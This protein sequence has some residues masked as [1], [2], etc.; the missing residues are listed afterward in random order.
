MGR[1][2]GRL[3]T[4]RRSAGTTLAQ[5]PQPLL[6]LIGVKRFRHVQIESSLLRPSHVGWLRVAGHRDE[7]RAAERRLGSE[8]P[9]HIVAVH[10][11]QPDVAE[12]QVGY[13]EPRAR[14]CRL[15]VRCDLDDV[16][17]ETEGLGQILRTVRMIFDDQVDSI[18]WTRYLDQC[19]PLRNPDKQY[20]GL[21]ECK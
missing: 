20:L 4:V 2:G 3:P 8:G 19:D 13:R 16:A 17:A 1:P 7:R 18:R 5:L 6:Q 10:A 21:I 9:R 14:N 15:A 12:H 11:R